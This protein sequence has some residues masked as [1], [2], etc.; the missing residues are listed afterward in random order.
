MITDFGRRRS[1]E[2]AHAHYQLAQVA[3]AAGDIKEALDHLDK[4]SSMD[5]G[6]AG[7][8]RLLGQLAREGGQLDRSERAYRALLLLVRRQSPDS[9]DVQV[10][11]SEVLYELS[12][13]SKD[14]GQDAQARE[15][16]ESAVETAQQSSAEAARFTRVLIARGEI[17]LA[18][19]ILTRRLT[20]DESGMPRAK[21]LA[22]RADL[23]ETLKNQPK[24]ALEARLSAIEIAPE[25]TAQI[26]AARATGKKH[27]QSAAVAEAL[28]K[29]VDR[30]TRRKEDAALASDLLMQ[31]AD[32]LEND[33]NDLAGAAEAYARVEA[34]G[35]RTVDAWRALGRVAAAR[36]DRI[37]EIRVLRRLVAA[38]VDTSSFGRPEDDIPESAKTDA[39]Y[40]IAEVELR[41][42]ETL[43]SGLDT[44]S[45]AVA[46]DGDNARAAKAAAE[47]ASHFPSDARSGVYD[48]LAALWERTARAS[49]D[50]A[51][52][53]GYLSERIGGEGASIEDVREAAQVATE[54]GR[55]ADAEKL[56]VRGAEIARGSLD[57]LAGALWI[58]TSLAE[59]RRAAGDLKGAIQWTVAAV[60]ASDASGDAPRTEALSKELAS[61]AAQP[62]GDPQLAAATYTRLIE[63]E[64]R[65]RTLWGPAADVFVGLKD[66]EGY[67]G[68]V[69]RTLDGLIE[70]EDRNALRMELATRLMGPFSAQEDA[71]TVLREVLDEDPDHLGASQAL[72]DVFERAGRDEELA[73][74]LRLQLDRARDRNDGP[75][76]AALSLRTGGLY[77]RPSG[78]GVRREDAMDAYRAGLDWSP[79]DPGLLRALYEL[80]GKN[81]DARDR[82]TLGEKL[83]AVET[84]EAAA[85]LAISVAD[86]LIELE[87]AD[88]A[89]RALDTGFRAAPTNEKLKKRLEK[90]LRERNDL[91]ALADMMA[92]DAAN[93]TDPAARLARFREAAAL[94]K[95]EL[96][97]P[98]RAAD[99]LKDAAALA[100]GDLDLLGELV[101]ALT[102]SGRI[103]DAADAVRVALES[104]PD[105]S[106]ERAQLLGTRSRLRLELRD[107]AGALEDAEESF[108]IDAKSGRDQLIAALDAHK[109]TLA[110]NGDRENERATTLRLSMVLR[111]G[112][113][114]PRSRDVLA[115]WVERDP[116]DVSALRTLVELD[117]SAKR[118]SDVVSHTTRLVGLETGEPQAEIALQLHAAAGEGG[119]PGSAR[120]GLEAA[121]RDQPDH[122]G[123]RNALRSLYE[124]VSAFE[125]L[126]ALLLVDAQQAEGDGREAAL[127]RAGEIY[128]YELQTPTRAIAPLR[129]ALTL[130][131]DDLELLVLLVDAL[132]GSDALA[133]AVEILQAAISAKGKK[134]SP[135][136]A[137]LQQRMARIAGLS[138]DPQTQLEWLKVA[139]ETDKQSN[140]V[141]AEL[142]ELA[143]QLG[144]DASAMTALK[145]V[146]LQKTQGPMSKAIAF[147]RQAQIANRQGDHQKAV[148]W[149][150]R[151]RIEDAE[152]REAEEFLHSIG[153]A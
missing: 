92:F 90:T 97:R 13:L 16:L 95:G 31:L 98:E 108:R 68:L 43:Q 100:P 46:R 62:G 3:H 63:L 32:I 17:E 12:R 88:A 65:D 106:K 142:A 86:Q 61:L 49:G 34:L 72:A 84:G 117:S 8:L 20:L 42:G 23:L 15:L 71:I 96:N 149:A 76:V 58:P 47:A 33:V 153:E 73:D 56:L 19:K 6:H 74:L 110:D 133:E 125:E 137:S 57:G 64:P 147:L 136:L 26:E 70:P 127:R 75:A 11:S 140:V 4:A 29:L 115:A 143:I 152:L 38:G 18:E 103:D 126:A 10:G 54:L 128:V 48:G 148:L 2:R 120:D 39:L 146:T 138:G 55:D 36:G 134:R 51:L 114:T 28:K 82:V 105:E 94:Y 41:D 25:W 60:E 121:H 80:Y 30:S 123:I 141:A 22:D 27:G 5:L 99:V 35:V 91:D 151:A 118:W 66:R 44:L 7:I 45:D 124:S 53:L 145:V 24:E 9:P 77:A 150:R 129:E 81:D 113:D 132:I 52:L 79:E 89:L 85:K 67:E 87:D 93:R 14:R 37:E 112:G 130:K 116:S 78:G 83:L 101:D 1:P 135:A 40:R 119:D 107:T 69:R 122:A 144:D 131:E 139:L 104:R 109:D 102:Q 111:A 21:V 50:K 59:R